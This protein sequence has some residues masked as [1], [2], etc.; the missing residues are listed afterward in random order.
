MKIFK[1]P[2]EYEF[3]ALDK[4]K[5]NEEQ[6]YLDVGSNRG[7]S[8]VS[9]MLFS[10]ENVN[11]VGFE[12]NKVVCDKIE[13]M[14]FKNQRVEMHNV[15]LAGENKA[16]DF[17]IPFYRNWMFDGL[18][19]F[20]LV[21]VNQWLKTRIY[22]YDESKFRLRKVNCVTRKLDDFGLNPYFIKIDVEG[23]EAEVLVGATETIKE[24]TPILLLECI[25]DQAKKFLEE[26][27][28]ELFSF[29]NGKLKSG[30]SPINTFC[31][32]PKKHAELLS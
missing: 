23:F 32:H 19:S 3:R 22:G 28:Y 30:R 10:P 13:K 8:I 29:I 18:S 16:F 6:V 2:H 11:I 31:L 1:V 24:H 14:F 7:Q 26:N 5:P 12:P 9:M 20:D 15:G 21:G 17:Y 25:N 27:G 4:F